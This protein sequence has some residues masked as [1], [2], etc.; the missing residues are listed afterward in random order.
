MWSGACQSELVK[1]VF[2]T[3]FSPSSMW[4]LVIKLR[5]WVLMENVV[6]LPTRLPF[7]SFFLISVPLSGSIGAP[8]TV[9]RSYPE[10]QRTELSSKRPLSPVTGG[11][12]MSHYTLN[13]GLGFWRNI[14]SP[15]LV[16]CVMGWFLLLCSPFFL[17]LLRAVLT[18]EPS[19][20]DAILGVFPIQSD[21]AR[22][23]IVLKF[24][25]KVCLC[26]NRRMHP[27]PPHA[28]H[29]PPPRLALS[30]T[31]MKTSG[32]LEEKSVASQRC[33]TPILLKMFPSQDCQTYL[34]PPKQMEGCRLKRW[35]ASKTRLL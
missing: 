23:F 10:I 24:T 8:N 2:R 1:E 27:P 15:G 35:G 34:L 4:Y 32:S 31:R 13:I 5:S 3:W 17:I 30:W 19:T 16:F 26:S 22:H 11:T 12:R 21:F 28:S 18:Q 9:T 25:S 29:N 7:W 33:Q 14:S 20:C 6:P